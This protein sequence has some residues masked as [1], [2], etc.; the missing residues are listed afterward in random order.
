MLLMGAPSSRCDIAVQ[1]HLMLESDVLL[2]QITEIA[3]DG[4]L[5]DAGRFRLVGCTA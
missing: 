1:I 5:G 4:S 2:P 3:E